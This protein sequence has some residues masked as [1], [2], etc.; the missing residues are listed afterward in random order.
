MGIA[1]FTLCLGALALLREPASQQGECAAAVGGRVR[2][3]KTA[4][5]GGEIAALA[6]DIL[7][8][9]VR[10]AAPPRIGSSASTA[11]AAGRVACGGEISE[12]L[13]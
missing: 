8:M 1:R 3:V 9:G 12:V 6:P 13:F 5:D 2:R 10:A 7:G 11:S 4:S